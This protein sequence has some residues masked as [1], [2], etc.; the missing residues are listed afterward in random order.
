MLPSFH[1]D[2]LIGYT[3]DCERRQINLRIR[4]CRAASVIY[5][6]IFTGVEGYHFENDAFG[7][8]IF[9]LEQPPLE[10]FV[11]TFGHELS[12]SFRMG[13]LADWAADL[14]SAAETLQSMSINSFV[15][16][17]SLGLS[18][19]VLATSVKVVPDESVPTS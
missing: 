7:N 18:G 10:T 13:A 4:S 12:D 3:V 19:W 9:A 5:T 14:S 15:V 16:Q 2:Y 1:D 17:S 11:A 8:I 6:V